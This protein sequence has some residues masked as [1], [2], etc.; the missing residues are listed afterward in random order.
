MIKFITNLAKKLF[1]DKL[2]EILIKRQ[3]RVR[4]KKA[5]KGFFS[6][7]EIDYFRF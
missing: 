5:I 7:W 3:Q 2:G 6:D 1:I 4:L